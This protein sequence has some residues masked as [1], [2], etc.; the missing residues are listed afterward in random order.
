MSITS[1][2]A[3]T[4]VLREIVL[5]PQGKKI[6]E[7][8]RLLLRQRSLFPVVP[9]DPAQVSEARAAALDFPENQEPD[10]CIFPS[11]SGM[12]TGAFVDNSV[13]VNPGSLCRPAALG[14]F[15]A[16]RVAAAPQGS[17]DEG[18]PLRGRARV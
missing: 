13:I 17:G 16:V 5:R 11:V 15:A 1:A 8:H 6:E 7:A 10:V 3:L 4:P 2:D 18:K 9:R 14:T 12:P